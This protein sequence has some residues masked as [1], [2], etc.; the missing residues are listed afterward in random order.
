MN[1]IYKCLDKKEIN[2]HNILRKLHT[3]SPFIQQQPLASMFSWLKPC[4]PHLSMT[5]HGLNS[6]LL[7][8]LENSIF[9]EQVYLKLLPVK[10]T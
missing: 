3:F 9:A 10:F 4:K 1:T 2:R 7:Y 6:D 8:E 5:I